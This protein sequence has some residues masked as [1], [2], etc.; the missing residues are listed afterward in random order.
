MA[1]PVHSKMILNRP[2]LHPPRFYANIF[3]SIDDNVGVV[4][5]VVC[6]RKVLSI[7]AHLKWAPLFDDR[8]LN[9]F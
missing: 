3:Y 4:C 1:L 8:N 6:L 5:G 7:V 9:I 2:A